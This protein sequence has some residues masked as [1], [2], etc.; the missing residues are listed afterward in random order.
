VGHNLAE[1]EEEKLAIAIFQHDRLAAVPPGSDVID[2]AGEL[3]ASAA[4]HVTTLGTESLVRRRSESI[5]TVSTQLW[6]MAWGQA[7]PSGADVSRSAGQASA[8]PA[9]CELWV[10]RS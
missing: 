4:C 9:K 5:G 3:G 6:D 10:P 2:A 8:G 7:P 1:Q